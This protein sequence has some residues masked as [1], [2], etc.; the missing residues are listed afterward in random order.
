[1]AAHRYWRV[2]PLTANG[3]NWGFSEIDFWEG[4][5]GPSALRRPGWTRNVSAPVTGN[6]ENLFTG[7]VGGSNVWIS[8]A[9]SGAN[10]YVGVDFGAGVEVEIHRVNLWRM[11]AGNSNLLTGVVESSDDGST[12]SLEWEI[13][14]SDADYER[15][16]SGEY[17]APAVSVRP[18]APPN[19]A[20]TP[21]VPRFGS[22]EYILDPAE[23]TFSDN[24]V[25]PIADGEGA[26]LIEN[27][28]GYSGAAEAFI[29][30]SSAARPIWRESGLLGFPY[31]ECDGSKRFADVPWTQPSGVTGI[32]PYMGFAVVANPGRT[33]NH[34]FWGATGTGNKAGFY[35][36]PGNP[37]AELRIYKTSAA[38]GNFTADSRVICGQALSFTDAIYK[39]DGVWSHIRGSTNA[40]GSVSN[41]EVLH[42]SGGLSGDPGFEG[43]L[44]YLMMLAGSSPVDFEIVSEFLYGKYVVG[45]GDD[46]AVNVF[47]STGILE[48]AGDAPTVVVDDVVAP[49]PGVL[50][51]T[52]NVPTLASTVAVDVGTGSVDLQGSAPELFAGINIRPSTGELVLSPGAAEVLIYTESAAITSQQAVLVV[53]EVVP[54]ARASQQAVLAAGYVV[55]PVA[56]SQQ[57]VLAAADG[58]PC[59]T[60]RADIWRITRKDGV[61]MAFTS[62]DEPITF[63]G[64]TAT[65][66]GSLNPSAVEQASEIGGVGNMELE[67]LVTSDKITEEELYGGVY[68]DAYVEVWRVS[69]DPS[70]KGSPERLAAGWWAN[71]QH[72]PTGFSVEVLGPGSR[73]QQQ[74]LVQMVT[75]GCRRIFGSPQGELPP[76]GCGVDLEARKRTGQLTAVRNRARFTATIDA[77]PDSPQWANGTLTFLAGPNAGS[78]EV[79][80]VDFGTGE[81]V[82]WA[83]TPYLANVGDAFELKPGCDKLKATCK[84]YDNFINFGGFPD[85]PGT[86]AISETPDAKL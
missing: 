52:G 47:P 72:G 30:T 4:V 19:P 85:L 64:V 41:A 60:R 51:I 27:P 46:P 12:W 74:S 73:L 53:G 79:K 43:D 80:S 75:P 33:S 40:S 6:A 61:V 10:V 83:P 59:V 26:Y 70:F 81:I 76:G 78:Y 31:L 23:P 58:S 13:T 66:C 56:V 11:G 15:A 17:W 35:L 7:G 14:L 21:L 1:M 71:L 24:G 50:A 34:G 20:D 18:D 44:Y 63:M 69:W 38:A 55:P 57:A 49:T 48:L 22:A 25:T 5:Y 16:G 8:A 68:D 54:T 45:F 36:R 65:P 84:L 42:N 67:G 86:D 39:V 3:S 9:I 28:S 77:G 82:L 2:R 29:Q 62:H 37:N 32:R